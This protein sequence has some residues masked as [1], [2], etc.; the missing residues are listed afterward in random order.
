MR[1]EIDIKEKSRGAIRNISGLNEEFQGM[2]LQFHRDGT[3]V[4]SYET[5][6]HTSKNHPAFRNL[7]LL[8]L[9]L[10]FFSAGWNEN[11]VWG[12]EEYTIQYKNGS[13]QT[14]IPERVDTVYIPDG[15]SR[16]LYVPEL[17]NNDGRAGGSPNYRW[18][19]RWYR[20]DENGDPIAIDNK[21]KS[22]IVDLRNKAVIEGGT[23]DTK[24][25]HAAA[26]HETPEKTSLFWYRTF[27]DDRTNASLGPD[28]TTT[29]YISTA[30]GA[31]TILYTRNA[32]DTE[33]IVICDVSMNTDE[34]L[35]GSTLTEPTLSKRYKFVIRPASE[36][37]EKIKNAGNNGIEHYEI[38]SPSDAK[39][40]NIQMKTFP[41]NYCW[42]ANEQDGTILS[43]DHYVYVYDGGKSGS[44]ASDKQVIGLGEVSSNTTINVYAETSDGQQK[45]PL[46]ATFKIIPQKNAAFMLEDEVKNSTDPRR[47]PAAHSD[48]YEAIGAADFDMDVRIPFS[49]LSSSNNLCSTP[50]SAES[51]TYAFLNPNITMYEDHNHA[52]LQNQYGLY[53]SANVPGVSNGGEYFWFFSLRNNPHAESVYDRTYANTDGKECGYFFY[54]DASNE[55]GR[56]VKLKLDDV[57]CQY[58]ELTVTAWV[59]DMTTWNETNDGKPLPPNININFI[60]KTGDK[61]VVLHRFTSGDALTDYSDRYEGKSA[62]KNVGKWQQ[63]C[64]SFSISEQQTYEAYYLEV[65]NN[66]AHTYGADYAI[67]DVRVYKSKPNIKVQ[68]YDA[69][70]AATLTVSL[71]YTTMLRNMGWTANESIVDESTQLYSNDPENGFDLVKYRFGLNGKDATDPTKVSAESHV[72]NTYFSFVEGFDE[73]TT[74][75]VIDV[76]DREL[77]NDEDPNPIV[78]KKG[79]LYRWVRVNKS[80]RVPVPQSMY[81]FRVINS[82]VYEDKNYPSS[83]DEALRREKILNLRAVKDYNTAVKLYNNNQS[84]YKPDSDSDGN[85]MEIDLQGLTE[86]NVTNEGYED[87]YLKVIEE[88]Y[89]RLQ[90]PRIRCSW[91]EADD[92]GRVYLYALDVNNTDL[93]Y[94]GEQVGLDSE[95]NPIVASGE[96]HVVLQGAQ[97]VENWE[98]PEGD[99]DHST[100]FNLKDPCVLISPFKV[101][102]AVR[103]TVETVNNTNALACLGT[104]RHIEADLIG[105]DGSEL[106]DVAYSFDWFLGSKADYDKLTKNELFGDYDLKHAIEEF[107]KAESISGMFGIDDVRN[108]NV[109]QT[110]KDGLI[111]LFEQDL[112]QIATTEFTRPIQNDSI[113]AMPFIMGYN[114][115]N[116]K[117]YCTDITAVRLGT[118]SEDVPILHPGY[119][120][121]PFKGEVSLRLGHPNMGESIA[122]KVPLQKGFEESMA[123]AAEH[124]KTADVSSGVAMYL[125]NPD[126]KYPEIGTAKLDI[127]K[128][129]DEEAI[130]T[131]SLKEEAKGKLQEGKK[132]ELLIPFAQYDDSDTR[133]SSECDGLI[134]LPVKIVPQY[135]TWTGSTNDDWYNEDLWKQSTKGELYFDGYADSPNTD[136]NGS[137]DIDDAYSPLYFTKITLSGNQELGLIDASENKDTNDNRFLIG[138]SEQTS[139]GKDMADSIRYEMAVVNANGDIVPYYIN[140]VSEIYF[141][142]NASMYRQDYLDYQKA[143]VEFESVPGTPYWMASPLK[144]IYAGDMYAPTN[145]GRQETP[146]FE[147]IYYNGIYEDGTD[148]NSRWNPAFYQKA[149]DKAI[150]YANGDA[151]NDGV[152]DEAA[153][154]TTTVSAVKSNWSIEYNDVTVPYSLG[155]GFYSRVE[156]EPASGT[157]IGSV[158]VRLPKADADYKY[159]PATKALTNTEKKDSDYGQLADGTEITIDLSKEDTENTSEEVD[160]DG[161]HFLVGNPY[162]A[163]LKM[164][165]DDGFLKSNTNLAEKF[166]TLDRTTGSIVVGTPDVTDWD[167]AAGAHVIT[168]GTDS[169][170]APMTAFFIEVKDGVEDTNKKITFSTSMTAAKPGDTEN[171]YTRSYEATNPQLTLTASSAKGK[172]RAAVVQS[173]DASNQYESDRDAVTLLDSELD[174]PTVYTVAGNY[175]AA[176]NAV[177]D[178]QNIPLGVYAKDNEEIEL[179]VEGASQL[180]EPLYLY[181]AVTRSSTPIE[182]DSYTLNLTGSSHGRY[183]LTTDAGNIRVESDI[184]IYSPNGG[185]LII[186]ASPS[187]KLKQ[188]QIYNL[189]GRMVE[190]RKNIGASTYQLNVTQGIY[191]VRVI[192]EQGSAE[193]KLRI[194]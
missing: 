3:P 9:L 77:S 11:V 58:T 87:T 91:I 39:G 43:G 140:K 146:A 64:Y 153:N 94:V 21:F 82:T 132:Y 169:Y 189:S 133:L 128:T 175:A 72:G 79:H 69:C 161:K 108:S 126:E 81:S 120:L 165:G 1:N 123:D 24:I 56:W 17:R 159:E 152:P 188:V 31:S 76:T 154:E 179:T 173:F 192:S 15:M 145:T 65:Q 104:L 42:Y 187:D 142:P 184:R 194:R 7:S 182:G 85:I 62:N 107:R 47:N 99:A 103:I 130:V 2:K 148:V 124:L 44:L 96:Y 40:I 32:E 67:D 114:V 180:T 20:A 127:S 167:N 16:E 162:M 22:T 178:C 68:R 116:D 80:L 34:N 78:L 51:T 71:D 88:L 61:E 12:Q 143:W 25:P 191:I 89:S 102:P 122:L 66:T 49:E 170:I 19:V 36:I 13:R 83:K 135:L 185:Q 37:A 119:L 115:V 98:V 23:V 136:A 93:K 147:D 160:G 113:V 164:T 90:I 137:D 163:Y 53:H 6:A 97:A 50:M 151:N 109:N 33:D 174:A 45:S 106:S 139:D 55:P 18:Y 8:T 193:A 181:D 118:Y 110:I 190:S 171:V 157:T 101:E 144:G 186:A 172:S 84:D 150:T 105:T 156:Y 141:K 129:D 168:D 41:S 158:M 134:T 28:Q 5:P 46:L 63:L 131:I 166:W 125:N 155:K 26:L 100:S 29:Y 54:T 52:A 111:R 27:F 183:F 57:I 176:V 30:T 14:N 95:G 70:D 86:E 10:L 74:K 73:N 60:G 75:N 59:N 149:W 35:S 48:L 177:H 92:P 117:I 138:W 121:D 4:S 38:A 112:L